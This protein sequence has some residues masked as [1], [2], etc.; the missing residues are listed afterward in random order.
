MGYLYVLGTRNGYVKIGITERYVT[1]RIRNIQTGCPFKITDVWTSNNITAYQK[2]ERI[3]HA[4]FAEKKTNGEWFKADYEKVV[5]I[6]KKVCE[7]NGDDPVMMYINDLYDR[8]TRVENE[9][10]VLKYGTKY[11]AQ[12]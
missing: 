8:L 4:Y 7:E 1:D 2:C 3:M 6:A 5:P 9:L 11:S 12:K 10:H